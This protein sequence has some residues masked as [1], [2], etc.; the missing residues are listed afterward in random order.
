MRILVAENQREVAN[1][2]KSS[3]KAES[4]AVDV[5]STGDDA[6]EMAQAADF[7]LIILDSDPPI[8]HG[9]EVLKRLR[10][11]ENWRPVLMLSAKSRV[12]DRVTGLDSGA[13][14]YLTK[15][16]SI[17]EV[18]ARVRA[19][20]RREHRSGELLL[21]FSGL[22]MDR[23]N[24][25]VRR[26]K[27]MID[28]TPKEFALLEYMMRNPGRTL[29]RAMIIE[30][31]WNFSFDSG[32]NIVDVYINYLRNKVDFGFDRKIIR[33]VRGVGYKIADND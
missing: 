26:G 15:P 31:V 5:A 24:H 4:Y 12:E 14:D 30:H 3:L 16:F 22:E 29:T 13:D 1:F 11:N 9:L 18:L 2:L 27:K 6:F 25:S 7:D 23:A 28:L 17:R 8:M 21:R 19:L 32:T 20:L 33:T 10:A